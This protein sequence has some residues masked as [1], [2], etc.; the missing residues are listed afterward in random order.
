MPERFSYN[1]LGHFAEGGIATLERIVLEDGRKAILRELQSSKIFSIKQQITFRRGIRI[2]AMLS[3]HPRMTNS[4]EFGAKG[5]R[6]YEIIEYIEGKNLK[7]LVNNRDEVVRN[8]MMFIIRECAEALAWIHSNGFMHLDVKP[9]NFI[10]CTTGDKPIVKLTDFDLAQKATNNGP[11]KQ[12]GTPAYM[13][14]EQF[15][16]KKAFMAS[17]VFAFSV[18]AYLLV[19]G[20][21]PFVSSTQKGSLHKQASDSY[22]PKAP[23]EH[24]P[25]LPIKLNNAIMTGLEKRLDRRFP[26]MNT[27]LKQI[28]N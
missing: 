2:R 20:K 7:A 28:R 26:D 4:L 23:I 18:M 19:T 25:D 22:T 11:Y 15:K 5:L 14:P 3:P 10:I 12:S 1:I 24:V 17:D 13:A 21:Q 16:Q 27:F 8:N 6:P 9:E